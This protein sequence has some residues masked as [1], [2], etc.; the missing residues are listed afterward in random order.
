MATKK[1]GR[2]GPDEVRCPNCSSVRW[3]RV[4]ERVYEAEAAGRAELRHE[5]VRDDR[6]WEWTCEECGY[7]V[8]PTGQLDNALSRVQPPSMPAIVLG[9][10]G[11]SDRSPLR[12]NPTAAHAVQAVA[13]GAGAVALVAVVATA[14]GRAP[15]PTPTPTSAAASAVASAATVTAVA[16]LSD[17]ADGSLAGRPVELR[18]AR[19]ESVTGDRTFWVGS[20]GSRT[21][22]VVDE[23]QQPEHA[24]TVRAGQSVSIVGTARQA[25]PEGVEL[26]AGDRTALDAT[27][28]YVDADRV[29]V[30][31]R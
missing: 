17:A 3:R 20:A 23:T 31:G 26:S 25:P 19:V 18:D 13:V 11:L 22:V 5:T 14:A 30:T 28:L 27:A 29:E 9:L 7:S 12:G 4:G 21:L 10:L 16:E 2:P 24:V 1:R 6:P 8:R 15:A